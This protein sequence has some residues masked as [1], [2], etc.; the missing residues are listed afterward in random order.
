MSKNRPEA[1]SGATQGHLGD[2]GELWFAAS[3]PRGWVW[4][5]PR[6]DFGKD[7]L[8]VIRDGT[9]LQNIEFTVQIKTSSRP[10]IRDGHV[11]LNGIARSAVE[12]WFASP[13]PTLVVAVDITKRMGWYAWHLDLFDSPRD[14]F[15]Q[16]TRMLTVRIPQSNA[17]DETCWS[18]IR[19]DISEHFRAL[20]R[21]LTNDQIVLPL[22]GAVNN[23]ARIVGNLMR[24]AAHSIPKPPLTKNEGMTMFIEQIELRDLIHTVRTVLSKIDNRSEPHKQLTFWLT[25]FEETATAAFPKLQDLPPKGEDIPADTELAFSPRR[26]LE[27]RPRLVLAAVDLL[28]LLTSTRPIPTDKPNDISG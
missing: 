25:S 13:L 21:A 26:L 27:A 7:G 15:Q 11:L 28:G 4:Q 10:V 20:Q 23:I 12:Y 18:S 16:K 1:F 2:Q 5:P 17:L 19:R 22:L 9:N 6:R 3:L 14:F 24:L 8:I